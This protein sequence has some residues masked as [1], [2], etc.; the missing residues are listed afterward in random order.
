MQIS[1]KDEGSTATV[2]LN[3][4]LDIYGA[5]VVEL[6]LATLSGSK[7]G[8]VVDLTAVSFLASIGIRHLLL[9]AKGVT[10]RGGRLVL[11]NPTERVEAVLISAGVNVL[12]PI[13]R[14]ES[15]AKAVVGAALG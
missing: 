3:G 10:R 14:S 7:Q 2:I 13:V 5:E 1:I 4:K 6:P 9:A 15:E 12:M 8:I 11:L